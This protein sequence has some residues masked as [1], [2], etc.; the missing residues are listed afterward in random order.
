M[1]HNAHVSGTMDEDVSLACIAV[2][3]IKTIKRKTQSDSSGIA[4]ICNLE[5]S[6]ARASASLLI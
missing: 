2:R 5:S 4:F 6:E 3:I 1:V